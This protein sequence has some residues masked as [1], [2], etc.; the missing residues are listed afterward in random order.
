MNNARTCS[1][2]FLSKPQRQQ[3]SPP[4]PLPRDRRRSAALGEKAGRFR[5]GARRGK[6]PH[7]QIS[8]FRLCGGSE[9]AIHRPSR[10]GL[11]CRSLKSAA[12]SGVVVCC[13]TT[14]APSRS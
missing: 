1:C 7:F 13:T 6:R 3:C 5:E 9:V 12:E 14:A 11:P 4:F 2:K 8:G 10:S